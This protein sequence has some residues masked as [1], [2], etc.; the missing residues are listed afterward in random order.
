MHCQ[1]KDINFKELADEE[2][3]LD[4][5]NDISLSP[6]EECFVDT[7]DDSESWKDLRLW[8]DANDQDL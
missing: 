4:P 5:L 2:Y 3:D 1:V 7:N 6:Q 8:D